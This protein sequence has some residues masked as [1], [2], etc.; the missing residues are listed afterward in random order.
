MYYDWPVW[1]CLW[2]F[3]SR[4]GRHTV[5][6]RRSGRGT[7]D[8]FV[9]RQVEKRTQKL[10]STCTFYTDISTSFSS[11]PSSV[12][13]DGTSST[14]P[15][16]QVS[17]NFEPSKACLTQPYSYLACKAFHDSLR[18]VTSSARAAQEFGQDAQL[19]TFAAQRVE[20]DALHRTN[21]YCLR[22]RIPLFRPKSLSSGP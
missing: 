16:L 4:R 15:C 6:L 13:L 9:T 20:L 7:L 17:I 2:A 14:T 12:D 11:F 22:S 3:G 19:L 18:R 10:I 5:A 8:F 21:L 1:Q